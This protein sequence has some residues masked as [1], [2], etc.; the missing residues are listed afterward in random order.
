MWVNNHDCYVYMREIDPKIIIIRQTLP[1]TLA[2]QCDK[3]KTRLDYISFV[4]KVF[5]QSVTRCGVIK[6]IF[7]RIETWKFDKVS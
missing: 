5:D 1:Y 4:N 6:K 7:T 2:T 3:L